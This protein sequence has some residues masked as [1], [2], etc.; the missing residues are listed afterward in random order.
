MLVSFNDPD[1]SGGISPSADTT[2]DADN[3]ES[4][5]CGAGV[6]QEYN[7]G[8]LTYGGIS[9]FGSK[10]LIKFSMAS[11]PAGATITSATLKL[12]KLSL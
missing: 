3:E 7:Y 6:C 4:H 11:I 5:G 8:A 12:T 1:P 2:L 9:D 10:M